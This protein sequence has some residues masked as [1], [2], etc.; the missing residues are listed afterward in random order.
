MNAFILSLGLLLLALPVW[1]QQGSLHGR[2][3]T[4]D[5]QPA[6]FV[7]VALKETSSGRTTDEKGYYEFNNL[8]AGTYTLVISKVGF[9]L[10][11][12]SVPVKASQTTTADFTLRESIAQL[13]EVEVLGQK[14]RTASAT[15]VNTELIDIPMSIQVVGQDVI[16]QQNAFDLATLARNV[17]N[18]TLTGTYGGLDSY[19]FYSAR[20][21][22]LNN[23]QN[24]RRNGQMIWNMGTHFADNIESVEFLKGPT[25]ILYGDVAPGAVIN[26]TTKKPLD[27]DYKRFELKAGQYGLIRP[28]FDLSGPLNPKKTL[29][30]RVNGS[31]Q[32]SES[33]RDQVK[34]SAVMLAPA[35]TWRITPRLDWNV[36]YTLKTSTATADAGLVS[37]TGRFDGLS[38]ISHTTYLGEPRLGY[39]YN[40]QA[41][42]STVT[43]RLN[44]QWQLRNVAS[45]GYT[46]RV[47]QDVSPGGPPDPQGLISRF[48][49]N[50]QQWFD[51]R[52]IGLDL[53]GSFQTGPIAHTLLVGGDYFDS[54]SRYTE[55][56]GYNQVDSTFNIFNPV[57][58]QVS[59]SFDNSRYANFRFYYKRIGLYAQDQLSF[60]QDRLHLLVGLRFNTT[61]QG[62]KY[63]NAAERP[64]DDEPVTV[65]PVSPRLGIVYKP[66][67]WLS[68]F[69][70][71][72]NSYEVNT[73]D[74]GATNF[75]SFGT[76]RPTYATQWEAGLKTNLLAE[77]L[78]ATLSFFHLDKTGIFGYQY[79]NPV[80]PGE[81][82]FRY[83]LYQGGK[84]R[85]RGVELD[86][87]GK[88][89]PQ[90]SLTAS[91]FF[92][93][94]RVVED[95]AFPAGNQLANAPRTGFSLW[96]H[97]QFSEWIKGL[98]LGYGVFNRGTFY[99][100][101]DNISQ[102]QGFTTMDASVGYAYKGFSAQLNVSN[103]TNRIYYLQPFTTYLWQ[104]QWVRRAVISLAYKF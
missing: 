102:T 14:R 46:S 76:P 85:S 49:Y 98:S 47:S 31:Y 58:N 10:Q 90:L 44:D 100:T 30:Y 61:E 66:F 5:G 74:P 77:R 41:L 81:A 78:G 55:S 32:Q 103:L 56:A 29:L 63:D 34:N 53:T 73:T 70:S 89:S 88:I 52:T 62:N 8:P 45:Y 104:P 93:D 87:N 20:G 86:L 24:Y 75:L 71:Y 39:T 11:E 25:A 57:Y 36:E 3:T 12:V 97:Y 54:Y 6:P 27:Y 67:P 22:N 91:G 1:A 7:H 69:A 59:I 68:A 101:K 99:G 2:I 17:S 38:Q 9:E 23:W 40:D 83:Y 43:F 16:R 19:Q 48:E 64:A 92:T 15:K 95:V 84:H 82:D 21:F 33:F 79:E 4:S 35:F 37:P 50:F 80:N 96:A 26:L 94:A 72:T 51:T 60:W 18:V 28:S 13:S 65:E 42:Y